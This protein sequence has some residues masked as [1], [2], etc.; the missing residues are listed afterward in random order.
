[1]KGANVVAVIIGMVLVVLTVFILMT[2]MVQQKSMQ[3]VM[4]NETLF[5]LYCSN[6]T[7]RYG[8]DLNKMETSELNKFLELCQWEFGNESIDPAKCIEKCGC[9]EK[10]LDALNLFKR[11]TG[12][13]CGDEFCYAT[14]H[15]LYAQ[16]IKL[17]NKEGIEEGDKVFYIDHGGN[18]HECFVINTEEGFYIRFTDGSSYDCEDN[19]ILSENPPHNTPG[20]KQIDF[21]SDARNNKV[22]LKGMQGYVWECENCVGG[23]FPVKDEPSS[24]NI[25]KI[26]KSWVDWFG[27][28]RKFK[29]KVE[30]CKVSRPYPEIEIE[31]YAIDGKKMPIYNGEI[32]KLS[33]VRHEIKIVAEYKD[34]FYPKFSEK[35]RGTVYVAI[36]VP[37]KYKD[38]FDFSDIE[39]EKA[40]NFIDFSSKGKYYYVFKC[41][42]LPWENCSITF[43]EKI[44][45][46]GTAEA[47]IHLWAYSINTINCIDGSERNYTAPYINTCDRNCYFSEILDGRL[48]RDIIKGDIERILE[49]CKTIKFELKLRKL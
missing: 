46:G 3:K 33:L 4:G 27:G 16:I 34:Y 38:Y 24:I 26:E 29:F 14:Q 37:E 22:Y 49:N 15:G 2:F 10:I 39:M 28:V 7:L 31:V 18:Y 12:I 25:T 20:E 30:P 44:K 21:V 17:I 1:M 13:D 35:G 32:R 48:A 9:S 6:I 42:L 41:D 8:C 19:C 23:E 43:S 45:R 40:G 11:Y 36:V 5:N 47:Y